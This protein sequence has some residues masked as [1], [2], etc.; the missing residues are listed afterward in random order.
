MKTAFEIKN[1]NER[2]GNVQNFQTNNIYDTAK[3]GTFQQAW[4]IDTDS[5]KIFNIFKGGSKNERS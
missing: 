5:I 4:Y 2:L 1:I 3:T